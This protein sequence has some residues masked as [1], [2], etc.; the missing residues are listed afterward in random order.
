MRERFVAVLL[1]GFLAAG[2]CS[3]G[4][5][6]GAQDV[7][8]SSVAGSGGT[9]SPLGHVEFIRGDVN[10]DL[11]IGISDAIFMLEFLFT[12]GPTPRCLATLDSDGD[13]A[14]E[15]LVDAIYFLNALFLDGTPSIP[16]PSPNCG[17]DAD[18]TI[19]LGC[20]ETACP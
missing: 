9:D 17:V 12:D 6:I 4:L 1:L 5:H 18:T 7:V 19:N 15:G 8:V 10:G 3:Q 20:N 2:L 16:A 11:F 13:D 14:V